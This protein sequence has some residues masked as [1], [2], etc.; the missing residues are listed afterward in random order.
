MIINLFYN[1]TML[2]LYLDDDVEDSL[3]ICVLEVDL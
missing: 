1:I 3:D 2:Y